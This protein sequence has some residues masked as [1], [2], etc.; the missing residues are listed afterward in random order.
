MP[1]RQHIAAYPDVRA[2]SVD[3]PSDVELVE[4]HMAADEYWQRYR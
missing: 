4:Q 1:F 2:C 3:S